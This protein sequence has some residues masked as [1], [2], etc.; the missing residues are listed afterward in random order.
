ML[1]DST[2]LNDLVREDDAAVTELDVLVR[3]ETSVSLS[4]LTVYEVGVG[5]RG[6]AE[7]YRSQYDAVL[8]EVAVVPFT[9]VTA[10]RAVSIQ[11]ELLDR[12][13]RIGAVDALLAAT[14]LTGDDGRILTRNVDEFARVPGLSVETY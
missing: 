7:Q 8:R 3:N 5:L 1:V 12:G 13:E 10:D 14:A 9:R 4:A 11:H 2:F 6:D